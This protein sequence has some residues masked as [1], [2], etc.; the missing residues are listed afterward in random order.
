MCRAGTVTSVN[1]FLVMLDGETVAKSFKRL[2]SYDVKAGDRV[3][4]IK[5]GTSYVVL[6]GVV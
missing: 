6:G 1:P 2:K 4:C 3:L 5:E